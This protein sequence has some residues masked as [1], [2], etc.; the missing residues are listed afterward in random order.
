MIWCLQIVAKV[1]LNDDLTAAISVS[2]IIYDDQCL[3]EFQCRD[4]RQIIH[5]YINYTDWC[6]TVIN[7]LS[8]LIKHK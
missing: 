2:N 8:T 1:Q 4:F 6:T 3:S 5:I 7:E